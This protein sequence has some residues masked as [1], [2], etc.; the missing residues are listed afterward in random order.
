MAKIIKAKYYPR[1][2]LL[3]AKVGYL[4]GTHGAASHQQVEN[5][6]IIRLWVDGWLLTQPGHQI[7]TTTRDMSNIT[8]VKDLF[9]V[10]DINWSRE[11]MQSISLPFEA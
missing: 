1:G 4:L 6:D 10:G 5:G 2:F 7:R 11:L 3:E 9:K 8:I